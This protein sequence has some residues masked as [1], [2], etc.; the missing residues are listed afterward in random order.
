MALY[1][2]VARELAI[3]DARITREPDVG[4][5][6]RADA[7]LRSPDDE[8]AYL[9]ELKSRPPD[10]DAVAHLV[11]LRDLWR[12]THGDQSAEAVLVAPEVGAR[13]R[14]V[15]GEAGVRIVTVPASLLPES[16]EDVGS[17]PLT[18]PKSWAVVVALL[19][20]SETKGTRGLAQRAGAST[21]WVSQVVAELQA[22]GAVVRRGN[23]LEVEDPAAIFD[24]VAAER[25]FPDLEVRT[26]E[27]GLDDPG[28]VSLSLMLGWQ[29]IH[30]DEGQ[31]GLQVCGTTAAAEHAGTAIQRDRLDVY[32][33]VP[34]DL[35]GIFEG[36]EGGIEVHV[37]EPDRDVR[38]TST[39]RG[40]LPT[41]SEEQALLDVAGTGMAFRD[42]T[43]DLLEAMRA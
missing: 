15:A 43:L 11:L 33:E 20:H 41:V 14:R 7:L 17:T 25:P 36:R 32:C 40:G 21:G 29:Q 1:E 27:T 4:G 28:D 26:I 8:Q 22:R 5:G 13:T 39:F 2:H 23:A 9:V 12:G 19:K 24:A 34:E 10:V 37:F 6:L 30:G 38:F 3:P 18:T 31:P 35:E 16:L 42:L